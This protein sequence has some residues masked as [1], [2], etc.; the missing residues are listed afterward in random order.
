MPLPFG[1]ARAWAWSLAAVA[2]GILLIGYGV[3]IAGVRS[4]RMRM[5]LGRFAIPALPVAIALA[6]A[7]AQALPVG[8]DLADPIWQ[9]AGAALGR[10][11]AARVTSDAFATLTAVMIVLAHLGIFVLTAELC[12]S[13]RL[14]GWALLAIVC[15]S[16]AYAAYG[17]VSFFFLPERLL[18]FERWAYVGDLTGTFVNRN[19]SATFHGLGLLASVTL[20]ARHL[21]EVVAS[22]TSRRG[23]AAGLLHA[24]AEKAWIPI[25]GIIACL[26]AVV[27][28]HSRGGLLSLGIG[29]MALL[30]GL[31][32]ARRSRTGVRWAVAGLAAIAIVVAIGLGGETT[33]GRFGQAVLALERRPDVFRLAGAGIADRPLTGHGLGSFENA[34]RAYDDGT[35]DGTWD[36]AHNDYLEAA[37]ELGIPAAALL[38]A[39]IACVAVRCA[40]GIRRRR[41]DWHY[42]ALAVAATA[43]VGAHAL[44]DF[45]LQIPAVAALYAAI[46]AI[47]Y[48]QSWR[49]PDRA[50]AP[51]G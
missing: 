20:L 25:V 9:S 33:F 28:A 19:S 24:A 23:L 35:L 13:P 12:R 31:L 49:M 42:P 11:L 15:A 7:L 36:R 3:W 32:S 38:L 2:V 44:V 6:W 46:L 22:S 1:S 39:G 17:L 14:A 45:S 18:W 27:L 5:P 34:F 21:D 48:A 41:R 30:I 40:L 47:G 37:F 4:A 8:S 51:G 50:A 29:T 26:G 16:A 43:L 10:P